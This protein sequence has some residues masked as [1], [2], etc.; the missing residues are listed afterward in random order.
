MIT[1]IHA[2]RTLSTCFAAT[3]A[4]ILCGEFAAPASAAHSFYKAKVLASNGSVPAP[5][6]DDTLINPWGIAV[7]DSGF[8]WINVN[9]S[10]LT[11]LWDPAGT[12]QT[13]TVTVPAAQAGNNAPVTG[14]VFNPTGAFVIE[15]N[16]NSAPARFIMAA[17][18]GTISGWSPDVTPTD[19]AIIAVD[20]SG[21][22][23]IYK[24]VALFEGQTVDT[25][26]LYAADF[27]NNQIDVFDGNFAPVNLPNSAFQDSR[28]PDD[29]A[30]F[31]VAVINNRVYVAYAKQDDTA[32]DEVKGKG[33]G[34]IDVYNLQGSLQKRLVKQGRLNAPWAMVKAPSNFG[35]FSNQL[36]VGNF[37]NG[38]I[39]AYDPGTGA[40]R[41][42]MHDRN[43]HNIHIEGLWGLAFGNGGDAGPSNTLFFAGGPNDESGGTFGRITAA[44]SATLTAGESTD[45]TGDQDQSSDDADSGD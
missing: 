12:R 45:E 25:S 19:Q 6:T 23:A 13:L 38:R 33:F 21:F 24:G 27:H 1:H 15:G 40:F 36:L 44:T 43:G 35:K 26:R 5:T 11:E 9:G 41:G 32:T 17:E 20:R 34:Y 18:D 37:G 8:L 3:L 28:L 7:P 22:G 29:Y 10:G 39:N 30:P 31:N 42:T 4:V 16:T 2:H 14:I